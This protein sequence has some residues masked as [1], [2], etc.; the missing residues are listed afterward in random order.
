MELIVSSSSAS[1]IAY[2]LFGGG[3][4]NEAEELK[5]VVEM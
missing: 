5:L 1:G 2:L 3:V 4:R